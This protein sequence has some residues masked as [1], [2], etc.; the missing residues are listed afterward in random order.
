MPLSWESTQVQGDLIKLAEASKLP[1]PS[2]DARRTRA[3]LLAKGKQ[4]SQAADEYRDLLGEVSAEDRPTVQIALA[5]ALRR[6]GQ[7][8][9]AKKLLESMP[10]SSADVNAARLFNLGGNRTQHQ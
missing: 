5:D 8:R 9:E 6:S 2:P 4:F 3:D 1:P 10:G 7:T